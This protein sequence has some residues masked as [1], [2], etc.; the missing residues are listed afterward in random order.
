MSGCQPHIGWHLA[1]SKTQMLAAKCGR[2]FGSQESFHAERL[3]LMAV[4][5]Y[6][7]V[8]H[9]YVNTCDNTTYGVVGSNPR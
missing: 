1:V 8:A 4:Y 9:Y 7:G 2:V 6:V 3:M 5:Y